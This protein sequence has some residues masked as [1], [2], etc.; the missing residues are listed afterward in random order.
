MIAGAAE[1]IARLN[2]AGFD[3]AVCTNQPEVARMLA[4]KGGSAASSVALANARRPVKPAAGMLRQALADYGAR[5]A[6]T[7]FV[8]DQVD[9]LKAAS[10]RNPPGHR[11]ISPRP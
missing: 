9:D 10:L 8:G 7:P 3:G 5:A 4:A 11:D 1:A 2:G 6:D